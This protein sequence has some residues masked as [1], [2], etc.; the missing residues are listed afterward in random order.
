MPGVDGAAGPAGAPGGLLVVASNGN[1]L[2]TLLQFGAG[3]PSLV[4]VQAPGLWLVVNVN[5]DGIWPSSFPSFYADA[6]CSS[7]PF[8]PHDA[9]PVPFFRLLQSV[10]PAD[11]AGYYA[12]DP[13]QWQAFLGM[14]ELGRPG[15]CQPTAG[16][17]WDQ[18]MLS[19]PQ[20]TFDLSS[21][22]APFT[23]RP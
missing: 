15:T 2:G 9:N 16:T 21:F 5:P 22:P 6:A 17:G 18:V 12:G 19:G 10:T 11:A 1:T 23:I 13:P 14:S 7:P 4:A 20:Q 3:Q 8:L